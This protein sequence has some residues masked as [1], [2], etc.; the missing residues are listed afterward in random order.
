L[1]ADFEVFGQAV[2]SSMAD[3]LGGTTGQILAKN[4]NTDMDFVWIT[5]DVGDITAVTAGTGISGGGTSGAVTITNSMATEIAAKGDLIA[6][7]GSQTF[8]NVTVGTNGYVLTADS[9]TATGLAWAA[10][11]TGA[12]SLG[13]TAGKNKFLNGDFY[14][15]QRGFTTFT[16]AN[17]GYLIFDRFRGST[18]GGTVTWTNSTFTPGTAPVAGYEG[19][20][21][22]TIQTSGQSAASDLTIV[23]Q[24]IESVRTFAGQTAT[25]S[26][27]AKAASGTPNIAIEIIQYF[28]SGGSPSSQV[29]TA[30]GTVTLSTSWARYSLTYAIPSI[31]GKTLGTNNDDYLRLQFWTSAGTDFNARASSIGI[32]NNTIDT[33]G[34]Q[35]E[36]GSDAT[37]FQTATGTIQGELAACQRYYFRSN[38]SGNAYAR[39]GIGRASS[40]TN[41]EAP[42]YLPVPMRV[43]PTSVDFSNMSTTT[44]NNISA[45]ALNQPTTN[46]A[47]VDCTAS[48]LTLGQA[49]VLMGNNST[50]AHLGF[51]A[52]L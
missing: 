21:F 28:G 17:P 26:F 11:S 48:S 9:S 46:V 33:W 5:N 50:A 32:Q 38:N 51:N 40:A 35:I 30:A 16:T 23:E 15:N 4:S 8:D 47:F 41:I 3:L 19:K 36:E 10:P 37:A 31:S 27:W 1:P 44:A 18:A 22:L 2:D 12:T 42:I 49:V 43:A 29:L 14:V 34:F 25:I 24:R 52:E 6:G 13:F 39:Y 7:T 45:I 20:S